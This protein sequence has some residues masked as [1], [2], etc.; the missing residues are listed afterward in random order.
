M[1][2]LACIAPNGNK[3]NFV[4]K[5]REVFLG[6]PWLWWAQLGDVTPNPSSRHGETQLGERCRKK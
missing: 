6:E 2:A 1:M 4:I 3:T 5:V